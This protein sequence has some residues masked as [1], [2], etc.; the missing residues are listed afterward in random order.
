MIPL[1]WAGGVAVTV[2]ILLV[3][4]WPATPSV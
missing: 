3:G 2:G 1:I 4:S